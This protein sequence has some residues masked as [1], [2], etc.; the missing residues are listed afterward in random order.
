MSKS[1]IRKI[2]YFDRETIRNILQEQNHGD[3]S[4][5]IEKSSSV[6][7][8]GGI[9][10]SAKIKL[11]VPLVSRIAFLF[12]GRL[13]TSYLVKRDSSTTITSTE[14]SEFRTIE[15]QLVRIENVQL[16]DIKNSSTS[17]R[18]AGVLLR[19]VKDG[20]DGIDTKEFNTAMDHFDGYDTYRVSD[21]QYVRFNN[22]AFLSNYKRYDLLTTTMTLYCIPVGK[23]TR[24]RFDFYNEINNMSGLFSNTNKL[25]KLADAYPPHQESQP[26]TPIEE[27]NYELDNDNTKEL[28]ELFDVLYAC[29][30]AEV[31][32]D[33]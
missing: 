16:H 7:T 4:K 1:K 20:V 11:S 14:L 2:I 25:N 6:Q 26:I 17:F 24:D 33:Q 10:S 23:F 27:T 5:T 18:V 32:N 30:D 15:S 8:E 31:S 3:Y 13:A 19:V 22:T 21:N 12:S 29:V 9:E 28:I